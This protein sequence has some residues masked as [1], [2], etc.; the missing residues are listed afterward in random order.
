[1][2]FSWKS[3]NFWTVRTWPECV[4]Y[5]FMSCLDLFTHIRALKVC[6][7]FKRVAE[8]DRLWE[9]HCRAENISKS[10]SCSWKE[11]YKSTLIF[12]DIPIRGEI[13]EDLSQLV[14]TEKPENLYYMTQE[15]PPVHFVWRLGI[16]GDLGVGTV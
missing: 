5:S 10:N 7:T 11:T 1:M 3:L 12:D 8:D 6:T 2:Q 14:A 9:V 13:E 4:L 15:D 16:I